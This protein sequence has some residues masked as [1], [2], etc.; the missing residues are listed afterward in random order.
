MTVERPISLVATTAKLCLQILANP[1]AGEKEKTALMKI[2]I[3]TTKCDP[4]EVTKA[5]KSEVEA[6]A[7]A[8]A[9]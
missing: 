1:V 9:P 6:K 7:R 5:M 8:N 4:E 2:L 3:E